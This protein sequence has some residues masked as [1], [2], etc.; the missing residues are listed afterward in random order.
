MISRSICLVFSNRYLSTCIWY[1]TTQSEGCRCQSMT[2]L[3][4]LV[5]KLV[6][7][8]SSIN[9]YCFE[10]KFH[11]GPNETVSLEVN[12]FVSLEILRRTE[13]TGFSLTI[14]QVIPE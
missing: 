10:T 6:T 3:T 8:Q 14:S 4:F 9:V 2:C 11:F 13:Q 1:R 5:R 7:S 12:Q